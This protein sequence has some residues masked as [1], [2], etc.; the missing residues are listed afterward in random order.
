MKISTEELERCE[1][2][3]TLELDAK[4]EEKMLQKAAKRIARE[5]RIPGFR[6]GKAPYNV[7]VRRFG[8]EAVQQEAMEQSAD[9][10]IMDALEEADVQ[11]YARIDLDSIDWNPLTIKVK[12]PTRPKVELADYR[13]IRL[14]VEP[15]EVTEEDVEETL[16]NLQ[17]QTAT[18]APVER[19]AEI[20][21]LISMAAVEKDGDEVLAERD[22]VEHELDPPEEHEGH[23]HPDLTTPLLG[24]SAG[25]E[26]SFTITYPEEFGDERYA[27]KDITFEVEILSVKEKEVDPIDD[28]F[29]K[30]ISDFDTLEELKEDTK[31]K[32]LEQREKQRDADLGNQT[33]E[34]MIE[35][36]E[37]I[38]PLAFEE[39]NVEQEIERYERQ[40]QAYGLAMD[41][42][43]QMQN[44]TR[45][46]FKE[47]TRT[48]VV[49]RLKRGLVLGKVAEL[50]KLAVSESEILEHAKWLS[51]IS[52]RGEQFWRNILA[53][54]AQQ[55]AIANE[56]LVEKTLKWLAAIAKGEDPQPEAEAETD[57]VTSEASEA[58]AGSESTTEDA[59]EP[60]DDAEEGP[61]EASVE[62]DESDTEPVEEPAETKA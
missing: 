48:E 41:N 46:E 19:P 52:G 43:L 17:E 6:P 5:V 1:V 31:K 32:L 56:L 39:E 30:S 45:E 57:G 14:D 27:G 4:Q 49:N 60:S 28:E 37:I 55:N 53:S 9:K 26:K 35:D 50:E 44:K 33:L 7:V 59:D 47:E 20:G 62:Q 25:D 11:P 38:W 21:D 8:L 58:D 13:D 40:M 23:N 24:L 61:S 15:V 18:W 34:K 29:A 10:M 12:V 16:K 42:F 54:E 51:D 3:V 2:L 22:S 36:A